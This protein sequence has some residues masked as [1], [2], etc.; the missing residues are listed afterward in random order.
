MKVR[1]LVLTA[2]LLLGAA[3]VAGA[4]SQGAATA[5]GSVQLTIEPVMQVD[6]VRS[7]AVPAADGDY[8]TVPGATRVRVSANFAWKLVVVRRLNAELLASAEPM[9]AK[10]VQPVWVRADASDRRVMAVAR[11]FAETGGGEVVVAQGE[12]GGSMEVVLDYRWLRD[13]GADPSTNLSF[14]LIPR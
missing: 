1:P 8:Y 10:T 13:A 12:A 2:G 9:A 7:T 4:Q 5:R 3:S 14:V 11:K 6:V